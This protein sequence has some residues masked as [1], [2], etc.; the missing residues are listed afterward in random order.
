MTLQPPLRR[1]LQI[2]A[3]LSPTLQIS[4]P[5]APPLLMQPPV[6]R[7][8]S[9]PA[10]PTRPPHALLPPP[11]G[12]AVSVATP[13]MLSPPCR[14]DSRQRAPPSWRAKICWGRGHQAREGGC[15]RGDA[16]RG[17][18]PRGDKEAEGKTVLNTRNGNHPPSFDQRMV[19]EERSSPGLLNHFLCLAEVDLFVGKGPYCGARYPDRRWAAGTA[20]HQLSLFSH[21]H[22]PYPRLEGGFKGNS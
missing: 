6:P 1:L 13:L 20:A 3:V 7:R 16:T 18:L 11:L 9:R 17:I 21:R 8:S 14:P 10:A 22:S 5:R 12:D 19:Q 15:E 4:S 2:S